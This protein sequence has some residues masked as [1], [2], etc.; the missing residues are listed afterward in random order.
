MATGFSVTC[1]WK[2][3]LF[4]NA[5]DAEPRRVGEPLAGRAYAEI[6]AMIL[7]GA[8]EPGS[9]VPQKSLSRH[10]GLGLTPVREAMLRLEAYGLVEVV[11]RN[12]YRIL[13]ADFTQQLLL[14]EVRRDLERGL[15][16]AAA[17][18][19]REGERS[20]LRR[21]GREHEAAGKAGNREAVLRLDR[22]FKETLVQAA[23]NPY[24]ARAIAPV[25]ALSRRFYFTHADEVL[26][27]V[28]T[29]C[30]RVA[31]AAADGDTGLA[32]EASDRLMDLIEDLAHRWLAQGAPC[33]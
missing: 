21:I 26:P 25:H 4:M 7:S 12:G 14:L 19:A 2:T 23:R 6:E 1:P 32:A 22:E 31:C 15:A 17:R 24:L 33:R 11:P 18:R 3:L 16:R 5:L 20:T 9:I 30:A 10:L 27:E 8:L 28:A 29:A 13:E